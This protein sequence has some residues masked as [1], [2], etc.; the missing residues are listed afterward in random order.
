MKRFILGI[1]VFVASQTAFADNQGFYAGG[2]IGQSKFIDQCAGTITC[3]D[4]DTAVK[5]FGGYQFTENWGAEASYVDFGKFT[6][7]AFI[8]VPVNVT[9]KANGFQLAGTG[10][11]PVNNQFS[12]FGKA[13]IFLGRLDNSGSVGGTSVS[14]S[15][16]S[17]TFSFGVGAKWNI[18]DRFAVRLEF[19]RFS[20][21]G[22]D[23]SGT[24][25]IDLI[26]VG[27]SYRF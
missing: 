22:S 8:G 14:V 19:E 16:S 15:G 12:F 23:A 17:T 25:D 20:K 3:S 24:S 5:I 18:V 13:G 4:T 27:A 9:A 1:A 6:A 2:S 10:T 21:V 7:T 11:I 26:S